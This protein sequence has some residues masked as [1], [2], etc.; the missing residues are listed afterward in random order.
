MIVCLFPLLSPVNIALHGCLWFACDCVFLCCSGVDAWIQTCKEKF[1]DVKDDEYAILLNLD[2]E[3]QKRARAAAETRGP[4]AVKEF[5]LLKKRKLQDGGG[6]WQFDGLVSRFPFY[7]FS[8][9]LFV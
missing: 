2:E 6:S 7:A 9:P 4:N 8:L 1:N 3:D 5:V